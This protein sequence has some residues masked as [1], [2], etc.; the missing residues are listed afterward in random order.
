MD[1]SLLAFPFDATQYEPYVGGFK[2]YEAGTYVMA[3][4]DMV[5]QLVKGDASSGLLRVEYTIASEPH[6]NEKFIEFLNLWNQSDA[7]R[8]IALRQL[9]SICYAVGR[10]QVENLAELANQWMLVEID[11]QEAVQGGIDAAGRDIKPQPARNRVVRRSPYEQQAAAQAQPHI[12]QQGGFTPNH[13]AAAAAQAPAMHSPMQQAAPAQ[14]APQQAPQRQ[15]P[16]PFA[17]RGNGAAGPVQTA[18]AAQQQ[19]VAAQP[20]QGT[21]AVPP[22]QQR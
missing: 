13:N 16:P 6:Q 1:Q 10:L 12:P 14:Q 4:T 17:A 9:S 7:A 5:P 15:T 8:E 22:W 20:M 18:P 19:T 21:Q 11:Y 3:I 2:I